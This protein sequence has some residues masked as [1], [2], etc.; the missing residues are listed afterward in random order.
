MAD[1]ANILAERLNREFDPIWDEMRSKVCNVAMRYI[2]EFH[3]ELL[4]QG[5]ETMA[6]SLS[7]V[8][9]Y[10]M[11]NL[12]EGARNNAIDIAGSEDAFYSFKHRLEL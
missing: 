7:V 5:R 8:S 10:F 6:L 4:T 2:Q 3:P 12:A 11:Q 1:V 9:A